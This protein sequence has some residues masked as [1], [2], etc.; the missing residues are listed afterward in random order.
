MKIKK[1]LKEPE[2]GSAL[3]DKKGNFKELAYTPEGVKAMLKNHQSKQNNTAEMVFVLYM[4][5]HQMFKDL[6]KQKEAI[7]K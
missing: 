5:H 2:Y 3:I 4:H 1:Q 7:C 6:L